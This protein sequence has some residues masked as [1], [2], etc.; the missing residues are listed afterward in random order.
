MFTA[1]TSVRDESTVGPEVVLGTQAGL[2]KGIG[3]LSAQ[4]HKGGNREAGR[5]RGL[6]P[7]ISLLSTLES[8]SFS[9]VQES[10]VG[11]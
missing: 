5:G 8:L 3:H 9:H 4:Q 6:G 1:A 2:R 10:A 7:L 11:L